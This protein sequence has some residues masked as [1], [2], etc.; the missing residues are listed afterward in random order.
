VSGIY[1]I[2]RARARPRWLV[3]AAVG[4]LGVAVSTF[5]LARVGCTPGRQTPTGIHSVL[6]ITIDTLRADHLSS[7]GYPKPTSPNLDAFFARGTRF[8][9]AFSS[10]STTLP[11]HVAMMTGLY[12]GFTTVGTQNGRFALSADTT[13]LAEICRDAGMRTA[14]II[15]NSVLRRRVGLDQGFDTYDD[16]LTDR[17]L[18]RALLERT[19]EHTLPLVLAKLKEL[20]GSRFFFWA[21]FQDPHGP[22]VPPGEWA[23]RFPADAEHATDTLEV[24]ANSSGYRAIPKYQMFHDE[25][26][27]DQ[28]IQRYDGEIGYLDTF[29]SKLFDQIVASG[30]LR[31][32]LVVITADHGEAFGEDGFYF[33]HGHSLGT[34]QIHVPLAFV[35]PHIAAGGVRKRGVSNIAIFCTL[36]D[37]LDLPAASHCQ[38]GESLWSALERGA[39]PVSRTWFAASVTQWAAFRPGIFLREDAR[40]AADP[41]F[42][43]TSDRKTGARYVPLG[44]QIL[45]LDHDGTG[46]DVDGVRAALRQFEAE[47][48]A[49]DRA[50]AARRKPMATPAPAQVEN[51]RALGYVE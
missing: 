4:T 46:P 37:A 7:Y 50:I 8:A 39:E 22:Y 17:E 51:L 30:M 49:S 36:L 1:R 48:L 34:D 11:S 14:A 44:E 40:P 13:T 29:L 41:L 23:Q 31:D 38:P 21:H 12:P 9:T 20:H 32:T 42:R 28:Y 3:I 25:R 43:I 27:V 24:D 45:P 18:N 26:R 15:S 2:V 5:Q 10:A 6:L 35:G 16:E 19:A 33:A 47:A